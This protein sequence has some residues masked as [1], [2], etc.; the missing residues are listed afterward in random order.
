MQNNNDSASTVET[1]QEIQEVKIK[2]LPVDEAEQDFVTG[3][4]RVP[5]KIN[6]NT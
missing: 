4:G 5:G 2:D 3:G 6:L 1:T